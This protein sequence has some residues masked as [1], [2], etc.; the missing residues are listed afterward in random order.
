MSSHS[1]ISLLNM[2]QCKLRSINHTLHLYQNTSVEQIIFLDS[3]AF[4]S[5]L[6]QPIHYRTDYFKKTLNMFRQEW[7]NIHCSGIQLWKNTDTARKMIQAW[8]DSSTSKFYNKHHDFEQSVVRKNTIKSKI[9]IHFS[10][11][12]GAIPETVRENN[13]EPE[14]TPFFRHI[15]KKNNRTRYNRMLSFMNANGIEKLSAEAMTSLQRDGDVFVK[16]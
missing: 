11:E 6:N 13:R 16:I 3:D 5:K 2:C 4:F 10:K 14:Y 15:T 8:W 7:E 9:M 12:V 1:P